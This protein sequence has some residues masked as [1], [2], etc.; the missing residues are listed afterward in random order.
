[1]YPSI[2]F[3]SAIVICTGIVVFVLPNITAL[4]KSLDVPLPWTTKVLIWIAYVVQH[5][6]L[7]IALGVVASV[8]T[9]LI[10]KN[11]S[12]VKPITHLF[13]L[14]FPILGKIVRNTNLARIMRLLGTLLNTGM[15]LDEALPVTVSVIRNFYYQRLFSKMQKTVSEGNTLTQALTANDYLIPPIALRLIRVGEETGSLGE[16]LIYLANFYEQEI[17]EATKNVTTL[18]EPIMIVGIG[19][20][21]AVLAFSIISPIYQVV[22]SI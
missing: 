13:T 22:G 18:I 11:F 8:I 19:L 6:G 9:F 7:F 17:D 4:F 14:R 2:V 10:I 21:V 3:I 5:Y 20:M 16:M 15:P 12:F 1:M